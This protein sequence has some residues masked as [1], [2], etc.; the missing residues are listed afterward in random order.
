MATKKF[1]LSSL[2]KKKR[3]KLMFMEMGAKR[4][5]GDLKESDLKGKKVL[6][7]TDLCVPL[8]D[9]LKITDD[10]CIKKALPTINYLINHGAIVIICSHL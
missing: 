4:S 3:N 6:V 9:N 5:V 7:R 10:S 8:D 1:D 2:V